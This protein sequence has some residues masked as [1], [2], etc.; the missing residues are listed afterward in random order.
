MSIAGRRL[1]EATSSSAARSLTRVRVRHLATSDLHRHQRRIQVQLR[2]D[3]Q[4]VRI[5]RRTSCLT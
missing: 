1:S 3:T 2:L 5:E 4:I